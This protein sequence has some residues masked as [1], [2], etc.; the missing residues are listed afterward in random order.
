MKVYENYQLKELNGLKVPALARFYCVIKSV[1]EIKELIKHPKWNTLPHFILGGGMNTVFVKDYE[2]FVINVEIKGYE[3]HERDDGCL[4]KVG[5]GE[6]WP[7]FVEKC[8][9]KGYNGNENLA[10]VPGKVGAAPVQ[11]IAVYGHTQED[12]F[13][14]LEAVNLE[15]GN[16]E[17]F[18][19]ED[20]G[21]VYRYSRFKSKDSGKYIVTSV[22]YELKKDINYSANLS[23]WERYRSLEEVMKTIAQPPYTLRNVFDA[24]IKLRSI[25]LPNLDEFGSLGSM[26]LNPFVYK[27]DLKKIEERFPD[28]QFYPVNYMNYPE[29]S[30]LEAEDVVKVAAGWIFEELG[31]RNKWIGNVGTY[32][33]HAMVIVSREGVTGDEVLNLVNAMKKDFNDATGIELEPEIRLI[34]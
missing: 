9:N 5:A 31:W 12:T 4:V 30:E 19:K 3:W 22:T 13:V 1:E 15:T 34:G 24:V 26:F 8:V 20:C 29:L 21:F 11:N 16:L 18:E 17:T 23:Y 33:E 25:K 10:G 7:E 28:I 6:D 32:R 14:R 27:K 2:G